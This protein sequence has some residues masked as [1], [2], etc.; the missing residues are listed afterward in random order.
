MK[1]D[2]ILSQSKDKIQSAKPV[3]VSKKTTFIDDV[4]KQSS[5]L[6]SPT[7]Y[8]PKEIVGK[9]KV[10]DSTVVPPDRKTIFDDLE[11]L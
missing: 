11:R 1:Q 10:V 3:N 5:K 8:D 4:R 2:R 7:S 6:P 9:S